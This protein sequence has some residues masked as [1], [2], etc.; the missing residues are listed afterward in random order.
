MRLFDWRRR[1]RYKGKAVQRDAPGQAAA[2]A[3]EL[4]EIRAELDFL[5]T[6][7]ATY[8]GDGIAL[9]Y[10][11]DETPIFVNANDVGGPFNL[12]NGG[13]YEEEN[14]QVLSSFLRPD[15]IF[16]DIGANLGY[17]S[18]SIGKRLGQNGKV[19]AFEPHPKLYE[20]LTRN[21]YINTL[22][23]KVACFNLALSDA[24]TKATLQ[25]P[26]SHLGGGHI[27]P[28]GEVSGHNPVMA[29]T[30]RLDD[31]LGTDFRCD[32]VKIDVEGHELSV[33]RG[34]RTIV[35]KSP[36]IKI[37]FEKLVM[38]AGNENDLEIYFQEM[39]FSLYGVRGDASLVELQKGGL[40]S[41]GGYVLAARLGAIGDNLK[42]M[43]FSVYGSQLWTPVGPVGEFGPY[44]RTGNKGEMLFHGPYWFL[45]S[46]IWRLKFH[47]TFRGVLHF[48][49]L[50]RFGHRVIEFDLDEGQMEHVFVM[51]RYLVHFECAAYAASHTA[52]VNV[53]RLEFIRET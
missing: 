47:G 3:T 13:R 16:I 37:L 4:A 32:L 25:Y 27:G 17:F 45:P 28:P 7:L 40:A 26:V 15:T 52:E 21:V 24:D 53:E 6:R 2:F 12:I 20:L 19:Y 9:T 42:R 46:G 49:L 35:Q 33:L 18:I 22:N 50:Q 11:I 39:G 44:A 31:L 38:N 34:M 14:T 30:K 51:P 5:R 48:A 1:R 10:L 8:V 43:R 29:E 36:N 23:N 41:W